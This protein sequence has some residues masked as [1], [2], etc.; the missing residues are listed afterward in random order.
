MEPNDH[1][2]FQFNI[3]SENNSFDVNGFSA[4]PV[5]KNAIFPFRELEKAEN[6]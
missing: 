6:S 5:N 3:F 4:F 1:I 2:K